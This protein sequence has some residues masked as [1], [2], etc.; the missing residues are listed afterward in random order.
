MHFDRQEIL[1]LYLYLSKH[2]DTL[3]PSLKNVTGKVE[4][5]VYTNFTI[6][7]ISSLLEKNEEGE[8]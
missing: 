3:N 7:E 1:T 2:Y 8:P 5:F 4:E 6:Q